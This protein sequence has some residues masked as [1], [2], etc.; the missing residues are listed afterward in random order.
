MEKNEDQNPE[1]RPLAFV[2]NAEDCEE[3]RKDKNFYVPPRKMFF[4]I[5]ALSYN[6]K[7]VEYISNLRKELILP[8]DGLGEK[9]YISE[10]H[11]QVKLGDGYESPVDGGADF[12]IFNAFRSLRKNYHIEGLLFQN[13]Y[14]IILYG[15]IK[16]FP[17]IGIDLSR[18]G[19]NDLNELF[20]IPKITI[21]IYNEISQTALIN[22]IKNRWENISKLMRGL[23]AD[24]GISFTPAEVEVLSEKDLKK[25]Q[26][27]DF[28]DEKNPY[29]TEYSTSAT[30]KYRARLKVN[31]LFC[32]HKEY[33]KY[34][35]LTSPKHR[36]NSKSQ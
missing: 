31:A 13:F 3:K 14:N 12:L 28:Y 1:W 22:G 2:K 29:Y 9:Y 25:K 18:D 20:N 6:E 16:P 36:K 26:S 19:S 24:D 34:L 23:P 15:V 35:Q 11:K 5:K 8:K 7:F 10:W 27:K 21:N 33:E 30:A 4:F 17:T 32:T